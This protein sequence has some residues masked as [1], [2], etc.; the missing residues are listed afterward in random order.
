MKNSRRYIP[1]TISFLISRNI[2]MIYVS[3]KL[4]DECE[5]DLHFYLFNAQFNVRCV[6]V[7]MKWDKTVPINSPLY[8]LFC[9]YTE[10]YTLWMHMISHRMEYRYYRCTYAHFWCLTEGHK[11]KY[12]SN[13]YV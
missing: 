7:D 6:H 4:Y 10:M 9:S 2:W 13:F 8:G 1:S 11:Y 5:Y 3:Y 12:L